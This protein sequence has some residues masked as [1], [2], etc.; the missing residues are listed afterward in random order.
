MPLLA[1]NNYFAVTP[2]M[3]SAFLLPAEVSLSVYKKRLK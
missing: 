2:V 3:S 1:Y